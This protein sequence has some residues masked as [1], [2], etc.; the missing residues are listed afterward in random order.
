LADQHIEKVLIITTDGR[1]LV[2]T[3][4]AF[5]NNTNVVLSDTIERV[6]RPVDDPEPSSQVEHGLYLIRGDN[7]VIC[8]Q[9]DEELDQSINWS[10]VRG[11][12]I[13]GT[14]HV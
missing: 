7:V 3:L 11:E 8:G 9:V 14:K 10:K 4:T 2:G 6:I 5:D 12:V 13:G 1:T